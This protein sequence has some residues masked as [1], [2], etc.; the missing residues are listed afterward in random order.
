MGLTNPFEHVTNQVQGV[1]NKIQNSIS[2]GASS[3]S[4]NDV[5]TV[6]EQLTNNVPPELTEIGKMY[7]TQ[8]EAIKNIYKEL[9]G[10]LS[11]ARIKHDLISK[12][13]EASVVYLKSKLDFLQSIDLKGLPQVGIHLYAE[14]VKVQIVIYVIPGD[15]DENN[16]LNG[17]SGVDKWLLNLKVNL[18]QELTKVEVPDF[19]MRITPNDRWP[20]EEIKEEIK[21]KLEEKK[22]ELIA[23]LMLSILG[24]YLPPLILLNET[25]KF[26]K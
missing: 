18:D 1:I 23:N 20:D 24:D 11:I 13:E 10:F 7:V 4:S 8:I 5:V 21:V 2:S 25:M 14:V 19:N 26:F 22:D 16:F 3:L 15:V 12:V 9:E 6:L 17:E